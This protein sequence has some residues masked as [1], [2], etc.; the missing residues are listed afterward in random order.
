M[1]AAVINMATEISTIRYIVLARL[2]K[3][4]RNNENSVWVIW[5]IRDL[6]QKSKERKLFQSP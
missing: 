6:K 1:V 4:S 3:Q 2:E 5:C